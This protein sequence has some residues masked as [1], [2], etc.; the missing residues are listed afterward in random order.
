MRKFYY[1]GLYQPPFFRKHRIEYNKICACIDDISYNL[2]LLSNYYQGLIKD[3]DNEDR[4]R[5]IISASFVNSL[6][7]H[8]IYFEP[9]VF[10]KKTALEC[11]LIPFVFEE[12]KLLSLAGWSMDLLQKLDAYQLLT[13]GMIDKRS[14]YFRKRD[15]ANFERVVG[16]SVYEQM[17]QILAKQ[18]LYFK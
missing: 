9:L 14:K 12:V 1:S 17:G 2:D 10:N 7:Y 16:N 8:P 6:N 11:G 5:A 4:I 18:P 13:C 15:K 3:D